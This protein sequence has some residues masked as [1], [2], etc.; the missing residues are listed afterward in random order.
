MGTFDQRKTQR[1]LLKIDEQSKKERERE[2]EKERNSSWDG[3]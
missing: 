1:N 2:R 3:L